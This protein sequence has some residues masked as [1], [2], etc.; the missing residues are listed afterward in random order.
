MH[1]EGL[2]RKD[3]LQVASAQQKSGQRGGENMNYDVDYTMLLGAVGGG[4][5]IYAIASRFT[6]DARVLAAIVPAVALV[7]LL[8]R[9]YYL[10]RGRWVVFAVYCVV[11]WTA[12]V[13]GRAL[14]QSS[15]DN[16]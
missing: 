2:D 7:D 9:S 4:L 10:P 5:I 1:L 11:G 16:P 14:R 3:L 8:V 13:V 12:V 6:K 15:R